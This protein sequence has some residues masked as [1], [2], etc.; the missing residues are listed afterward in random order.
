MRRAGAC[1][2]RAARGVDAARAVWGL[3][4]GRQRNV[5]LALFLA[6]IGVAAVLLFA[7]GR[8]E[9]GSLREGVATW[10]TLAHAA[11]FAVLALIA[12][13]VFPRTPRFILWEA[14]LL[15]AGAAELVQYVVPGRDPSWSDLVGNALGTLAVFVPL[16]RR[17]ADAIP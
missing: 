14:L 9:P 8:P 5:A 2:R 4:H 15:A 12:P 1:V 3:V 10:N 17:G 13:H 11:V 6:A 7:P 16:R